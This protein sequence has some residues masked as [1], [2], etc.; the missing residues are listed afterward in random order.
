MTKKKKLLI[1]LGVI[2]ALVAIVVLVNLLTGKDK[3]LYAVPA[4]ETVIAR[5]GTYQAYLDKHGYADLLA[6][7]VIEVDIFAFEKS[8]DSNAQPLTEGVDTGDTG[9]I[10]WKFTVEETGFYNLEVGYMP[11]LGTTSDIQRRVLID[12]E[13]PYE[14]LTQ[15][16]FKRTWRDEDIALKNSNEIRPNADELYVAQTVYLEDYDRRSGAPLIFYLTAGEHT[17]T[18]EA[19]KEPMEVLTLSFKAAPRPEPYEVV[20]AKWQSE[21]QVYSGGA[22]IGQAERRAAA[23]GQESTPLSTT[24]ATKDILKSS[25]AI[26]VQKNYSDAALEP[27]H[28]WH[29]LYPTI[30]A[31]NWAQ[32]G[33]ALTWQVIAPRTACTP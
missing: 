17:L 8:E 13:A 4:T 1:A 19:V 24:N 22:I 23:E 15:I 12:G 2:V 11:L 6:A 29:I 28:A 18:F 25:P 20:L 32:P 7:S 3:A 14:A 26:T 31:S 21:G 5:E 27:Y 9:S 16:V 33:D 10:T 30:G